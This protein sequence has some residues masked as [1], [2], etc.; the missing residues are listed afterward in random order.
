MIE[1]QNARG[2]PVEH[3][4]RKR[5]FK[6]CYPHLWITDN[7]SPY[8]LCADCGLVSKSSLHYEPCLR[9]GANCG[10]LPECDECSGR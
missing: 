9:C 10:I 1:Y 8:W 5:V 6:S 4:F 2:E 7:Q 3:A